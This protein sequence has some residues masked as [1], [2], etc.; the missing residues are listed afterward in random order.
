MKEVAT[1][2]RDRAVMDN[3]LAMIGRATLTADPIN[4][5]RNELRVVANRRIYSGLLSVIQA[6]Y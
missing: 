5:V 4:G 3:S 2:L 6:H 1:Q